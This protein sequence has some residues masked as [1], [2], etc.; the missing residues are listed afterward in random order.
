MLAV[1]KPS[2]LRLWGFLLTVVGGGAL[3]LGALSSWA[4]VSIGGSSVG[5][6]PT[7]GIDLWQGWIALALGTLIV[8]AIM[9]LRFV[10]PQRRGAVAVAI[11]A[12]GL[13]A[14]A[15]AVWCVVALEDV[16]QD[17]GVDAL[18]S[19]VAAQ[20]GLSATQARELV[21]EALG[22]AG[23]EVQA[24]AGLWL[25][26]VG[27]ALATVGGVLDLAWVRRKREL[28][29]AI[30]VDTRPAPG[31]VDAPDDPAAGAPD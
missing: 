24:Q 6:V 10:R 18:V 23:I 7:K 12:M 13:L 26:V 4:A 3:A 27:A 20:L 29:D 28:G 22:S 1:V 21:E 31:P 19:M 2:P 8:V 14:L 16:V 17:T 30:D 15:L 5:A 25:T 9:A 11:V